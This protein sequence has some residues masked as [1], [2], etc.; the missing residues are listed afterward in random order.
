M[1]GGVTPANHLQIAPAP[2]SDTPIQTVAAP[3][4]QTFLGNAALSGPQLF[5]DLQQNPLDSFVLQTSHSSTGGIP[6]G[7]FASPGFGAGNAAG[8][9]GGGSTASQ[10]GDSAAAA[11]GSPA[12][13]AGGLGGAGLASN[14]SSPVSLSPAGSSPS[15]VFPV[16]PGTSSAGNSSVV[17]I[18]NTSSSPQASPTAISPPSGTSSPAGSPMSPGVIPNAPNQVAT[19]VLLPI[20]YANTAAD[21]A[22]EVVQV[23]RGAQGG[24]PMT[25]GF[26]DPG[27]RYADG[28][29]QLNNTDLAS[30]SFGNPWGQTRNWTNGAGYVA[31]NINGTGWV[32]SQMPYVQKENN[33]SSVVLVTSGTNARFFDGT[34]PTYTERYFLQ[35]KLYDNTT[36]Q[37]FQLT[38]DTGKVL[39][40]YD[41]STGVPTAQQGTFKSLTDQ[42]G[43]VTSV[44]AH[45]ASGQ[46]QEVQS[47]NTVG[48]TTVTE[49]Y[50]YSYVASGVNAGLLQNVT[51]RRQVNGGAWTNVRQVTYG[52]Y[53]GTQSYGN[54]GDLQTATIQDGSG[55]TLQT[56]YYRYYVTESGGYQ[57]SLKYVFSPQA[58]AR[59]VTAVGNPLTA[60]DSQVSPYADL[61]LQYNT[62][63]QVTQAVVAGAGSSLVGSSVG[64]GTYSYSYT[65]TRWRRATISGP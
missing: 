54:A 33:S 25:Q 24:N 38:D 49:S 10:G 23:I 52:Y 46:I 14:F 22:R 51:L 55:N 34:G 21:P 7:S 13:D 26:S 42:F 5:H 31:K 58:Y 61:Y 20:L 6:G 29:I 8:T 60:T 17:S 18:A 9:G 35:D 53:D 57:H 4:P 65:G 45:N 3:V 39:R 16:T 62:S 59:L 32:D 64:L 63:K 40:L 19:S 47:S 44:T 12:T 27:V 30:P 43:N 28:T 56:W 48:S 37:E 1:P 50:L 15:Q 36:A 11:T 41:F 2:G